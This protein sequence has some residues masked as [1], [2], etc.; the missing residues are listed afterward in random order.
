MSGGD[1]TGAGMCPVTRLDTNGV[2]PSRSA[3]REP[4]SNQFLGPYQGDLPSYK[5]RCSSTISEAVPVVASD[6]R[7]LH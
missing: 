7:G 2:D 1:V 3:S 5:L 4:L 6:G